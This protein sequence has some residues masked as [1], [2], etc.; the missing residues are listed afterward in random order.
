MVKTTQKQF[1]LFKKYCDKWLDYYELIEW[2]LDYVHEELDDDKAAMA[3]FMTAHR[4]GYICLNKKFQYI[5]PVVSN[6]DLD[7]F[8]EHEILHIYFAKMH[9][10]IERRDIREDEV[11]EM[12]HSY[13]HKQQNIRKKR[14]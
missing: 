11:S 6:A 10:L 2:E 9:T 13:I 7:N 1:E 12:I 5:K 3:V 8:A 14:S 4:S